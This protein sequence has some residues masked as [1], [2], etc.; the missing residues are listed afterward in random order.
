[1]TT[2]NHEQERAPPHDNDAVMHDGGD[3]RLLIDKPFDFIERTRPEDRVPAEG[4][5][6]QITR[7][8]VNPNIPSAKL[9]EGQIVDP[10]TLGM[11][12][13]IEGAPTPQVQEQ[14]MTAPWGSGTAASINEPPGS[15]IGSAN[16][17]GPG[18]PPVE[19]GAESEP[20]DL[21]DIDPDVA[22]IGDAD[23][24]LTCTGEN[25]T[26][27]SVITFNGGDEPT[28]FV[29]ANTVTTIVKPSTAGTPGQYPV[30]VRNANGE[31]DP[32]EFEFTE[33]NEALRAAKSRPKKPKKAPRKKR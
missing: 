6:G 31:S 29:D 16:P 5:H 25:F 32:L 12:Q 7:D 13:G 3:D 30:T 11:P 23:L 18:G 14:D 21:L 1:M 17:G 20:P 28:T 33:S 2:K 15:T 19:G 22:Q 24:T 4:F 27:D 26:A 10:N 9:G 8:N